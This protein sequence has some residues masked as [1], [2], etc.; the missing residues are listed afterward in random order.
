MALALESYAAS[1][2]EARSLEKEKDFILEQAGGSAHGAAEVFYRLQASRLKCLIAAASQPES[3]IPL[4]EDEALALTEKYWFLESSKGS[5]EENS[6]RDRV[7]YVL[8]DI[9]AALAQCKLDQPFFHRSVFRHA[10]A[11][12]WAP[13]LNDPIG[14]RAEGSLGT[15]PISKGYRIRGLNS[16]TSVA[17]SAEVIMAS[18]FEKKR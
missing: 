10:Q 3:E 17:S 18:L 13:V 5:G 14:G 15:V 8:S 12:M 9:V 11:L 7:W 6:V 1:L 16:G 4:A 2:K